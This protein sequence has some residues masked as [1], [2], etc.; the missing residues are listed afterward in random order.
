[1]F[2]VRTLKHHDVLLNALYTMFPAVVVAKLTYA[3]PA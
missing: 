1:L 3:S 2:A